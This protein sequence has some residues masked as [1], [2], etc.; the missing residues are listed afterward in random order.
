MQ[1]QSND[2]LTN[3]ILSILNLSSP[4]YRHITGN[5]FEEEILK[6]KNR[7]SLLIFDADWS[8]TSQLTHGTL[9][10]I[11]EDFNDKIDFFR[12][13]IEKD[14]TLADMMNIR[15]IPTILLFKQGEVVDYIAGLQSKRNLV[16]AL[17]RIADKL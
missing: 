11:A 17:N 4:I 3:K 10:A 6:R 1:S 5:N 2:L 12:A 16:A 9:L 7:P 13:D 14:H 15:E 8:G